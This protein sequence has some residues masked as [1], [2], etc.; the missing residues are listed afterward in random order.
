MSIF[1]GVQEKTAPP[2]LPPP[3]LPPNASPKKRSAQ[4]LPGARLQK[5][6]K[7][8]ACRPIQ[9]SKIHHEFKWNDFGGQ[10]EAEEAASQWVQRC[11][12]ALFSLVESETK[13]TL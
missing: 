1:L 2:P 11:Q 13:D 4:P 6:K 8:F 7:S 9:D 12:D 10:A 5:R 3:S